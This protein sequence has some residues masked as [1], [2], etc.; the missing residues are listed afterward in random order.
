VAEELLADPVGVRVGVAAA[1]RVHDRDEVDPG[2]V[3]HPFGERLQDRTR[4]GCLDGL[5]DRG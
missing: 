3:A 2:V 4:V 1:G 5:D